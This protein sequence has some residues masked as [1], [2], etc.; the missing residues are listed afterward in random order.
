[1]IASPVSFA[2][3]APYLLFQRS[4]PMLVCGRSL[5][6]HFRKGTQQER[7]LRIVLY[8]SA[9]LAS[10]DEVLEEIERVSGVYRESIASLLKSPGV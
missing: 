6:R 1:M 7:S 3:S 5:Q 8:K 2:F 4:W 9:Y 10:T